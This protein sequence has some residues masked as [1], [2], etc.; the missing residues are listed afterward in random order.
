M[1]YNVVQ[2]IEESKILDI[3]MKQKELEAENLEILYKKCPNGNRCVTDTGTETFSIFKR[4][5]T[6][7]IELQNFHVQLYL[8][9]MQCFK[10]SR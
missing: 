3:P 8:I 4:R 10:C 5:K 6:I 9:I 1:F 7:N 2:D